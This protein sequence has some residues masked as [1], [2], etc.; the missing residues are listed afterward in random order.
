VQRPSFFD[1]LAKPPIE[2]IQQQEPRT[3]PAPQPDKPAAPQPDKPAAP[4]PDKPVMPQQPAPEPP[5]S[6]TPEAPAHTVLMKKV[7]R[8]QSAEDTGS[9]PIGARED[10][11][12]QQE[13]QQET[14]RKRI[15]H[16]RVPED[17]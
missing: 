5:V 4:Q 14:V 16:V 8:V 11:L 9:L 2:R 1:V 3:E 17:E 15:R 7:Y 12:R 6:D 10:T 13:P